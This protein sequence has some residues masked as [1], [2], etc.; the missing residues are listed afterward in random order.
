MYVPHLITFIQ[1]SIEIK[2]NT[3]NPNEV[4][5]TSSDISRPSNIIN[6]QD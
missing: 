5:L 4:R 3:G 6:S 2:P 1:C